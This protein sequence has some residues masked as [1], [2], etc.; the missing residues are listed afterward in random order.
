[1]RS[2][3]ILINTFYSLLSAV[4]MALL[5]LITRRFFLQYFGV[6]LLGY[7]SLFSNVF[8]L[9]ALSDLGI[10]TVI[11]YALYQEVAN[12]NKEEIT[13]FCLGDIKL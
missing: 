11:T 4:I 12:D 6:A 13:L 9:L 8:S 10:G 3:Q 2:K 7:E 1:M 5:S